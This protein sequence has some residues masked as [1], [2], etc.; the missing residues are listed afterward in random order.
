[1]E[2]FLEVNQK[3]SDLGIVFDNIACEGENRVAEHVPVK[4]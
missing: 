3:Q 1:M 4:L 2:M